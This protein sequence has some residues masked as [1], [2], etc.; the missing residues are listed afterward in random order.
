M[1][2]TQAIPDGEFADIPAD[3]LPRPT[4]FRVAVTPRRPRTKSSGGIILTSQA[5]A[6]EASVMSI[7]KI[8]ANGP[9]AYRGKLYDGI[10][11]D[12][13]IP[14]GSIVVF[15]MYAGSRMEL[16]NGDKIIFLND[17][18]ILAVIDDAEDYKLF[19]G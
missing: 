18:D 7:G 19:N 4:L 12:P 6:N 3:K 16:K 13:T 15:G 2:T 9:T 1:T 8:V 17:Q 14:V 5:V 11:Q 10:G